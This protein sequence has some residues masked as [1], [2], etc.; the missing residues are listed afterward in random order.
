MYLKW[1]LLPFYR[2]TNVSANLPIFMSNLSCSVYSLYTPTNTIQNRC[3]YKSP[4]LSNC[5]DMDDVAV[6][7]SDCDGFLCDEGKCAKPCDG[8]RECK[9]GSDES[10]IVCGK[11]LCFTLMSNLNS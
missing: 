8:V 3:R 11:S 9:D 6:E 5:T 1:K 10:G 4:P 7:C 2:Y